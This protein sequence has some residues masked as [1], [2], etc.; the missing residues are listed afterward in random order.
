M[1]LPVVAAILALC[2][3]AAGQNQPTPTPPAAPPATTAVPTAQPPQVLLGRRVEQVRQSA[4]VCSTLVLV[5]DAA[6]YI[7]AIARW[8]PRVRFPVLIDDG[9]PLTREHIGQF[10]RAFAP[11]RVVRWSSTPGATYDAAAFA[12]LD[13]GAITAASARAW[14]LPAENATDDALLALWKNANYQPP[15][16]VVVGLDDPAWTAGLALA[17]GRGQPLV[18][19]KARQGLDSTFGAP[20]A[21]PLLRIIELGAEST[22]LSWR[23]LGDAI[24]AVTLC[25]NTPSRY[26]AGKDHLAMTDRIGRLGPAATPG[27]R[28]AWCGQIHGSAPRAAYAAMCSLFLEPDAAWFFDGYEDSPPWNTFDMTKAASYFSQAGVRVEVNDTPRNTAADW[29]SR[30]ARPIDAGILFVNTKGYDDYFELPPGQAR[31]ND[32]PILTKPAVMLFVHSWSAAN[33]GNR[34]RLAGR[35][36]ERGVFAY[37]GSVHEPFLQAFVPTPVLAARLASGAPLGAA[38]RHDPSQWWKITVLGDPLYTLGPAARR[39][40]AQPPLEGA[41][42][43]RDALR[44]MLTAEKFAEALTV[45]SLS[46]RD[47]DAARLIEALLAN[48]SAAITPGAA[49]EAVLPLFRAGQTDNVWRMFARMD[50]AGKRDPALRDALWLSATPLLDGKPDEALLAILRDNVRAFQPARDAMLVARAIHAAKGMDAAMAMLNTVRAR[51][52]AADQEQ[53]D[54]AMKQPPEAWGR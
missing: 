36:L 30:A 9:T 43:I 31:P 26:D 2:P 16:I 47:A 28:W 48:Q 8:S 18:F 14:G 54:A 24:D 6:S 42:E 3:V 45:L 11:A 21:E 20:E 32:V 19:T 52:A 5:P 37:V 34:D 4:Q 12:K 27:E 15:G 40:D 35:W 17:A 23:G 49:R 13:G 1:H 10:A 51:L 46:G 50:A 44:D 25:M 7:E 53:L 38:A 39:S 22:G 29:R 41:I 33:A